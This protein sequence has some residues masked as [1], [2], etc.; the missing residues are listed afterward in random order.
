ERLNAYVDGELVAGDE[1]EVR[2]HLD[3]CAICAGRVESLL[4]VKDAVAA[5]A[6]LRPV[7]HTLRGRLAAHASARRRWEPFRVARLALV[8]AGALLAIIMAGGR[9]APPPR[10]S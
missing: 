9:P 7:P 1:L 3:V 5:S 8:P 6:E 10:A 4:V 2:R